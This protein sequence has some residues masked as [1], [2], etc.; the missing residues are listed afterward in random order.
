MNKE[1]KDIYAEYDGGFY[2]VLL[3]EVIQTIKVI[4]DYCKEGCYIVAK[5]N[6]DSY[7]TFENLNILEGMVIALNYDAKVRNAINEAVNGKLKDYRLAARSDGKVVL[8]Y[9]CF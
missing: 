8:F 7:R 4:V 6:A 1:L 5:S 9:E 2:G 3:M